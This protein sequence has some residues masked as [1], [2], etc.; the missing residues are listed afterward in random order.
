MISA[1][2]RRSFGSG[3]H[4]F[5]SC[6]AAALFC[7]AGHFTSGTEFGAVVGPEYARQIIAEETLGRT[8]RGIRWVR[9]SSAALAENG[10][11]QVAV[12][13]LP[14]RRGPGQVAESLP[15]DLFDCYWFCR[16]NLPKFS[17]IEQ[18]WEIYNEPDFYFVLDNADHMAAVLKAC[19]WG[20]KAG[21]PAAK[22]LMPPLAFVPG[23]YA[24]EL[25]RNDLFSY[26]E[27]YNFHFYGW[28]Q[29]FPRVLKAHEGYR[30]AYAA[31]LPIWMT[32]AGYYSLTAAGR[33]NPR[34]LAEQQAFHEQMAVLGHSEGIDFYFPFSV[35]PFQEGQFDLAMTTPDLVPRPALQSY[36]EL[37]KKLRGT[38]PLFQLWHTGERAQ[39]GVVLELPD[40]SW[41]SIF[42]SPRR[43]EDLEFPSNSHEAPPSGLPATHSTTFPLHLRFFREHAF[44]ESGLTEGVR[45]ETPG[46]VWFEVS[47]EKNLFL[48]SPAGRFEIEGCEWRPFE[49]ARQPGKLSARAAKGAETLQIRRSRRSEE[50][51]E[52]ALGRAPSP[53]VLQLRYDELITPDKPSQTYRFNR[54]LPVHGWLELYN[55]S[56][57]PRAGRIRLDLPPGWAV[58]ERIG[59]KKPEK[60]NNSYS[61][62]LTIEGLSKETIPIH[63]VP[64]ATLEQRDGKAAD[65]FATRRS[66]IQCQWE[67][68]DGRTTEAASWLEPEF[69]GGHPNVRFPMQ[70]WT[71]LRGRER[72]WQIGAIAEQMGGME[73]RLA[74]KPEEARRAALIY[75]FREEVQLR[76]EDLLRLDFRIVPSRP[77]AT[78]RLN[79]ITHRKDIFRYRDDFPATRSWVKLAWRIEDF[80]P[81]LWTRAESFALEPA[82]ARY[83]FFSFDG[84]EVGD[85]VEIANFG[86]VSPAPGRVKAREG[87]A[88]GRPGSRLR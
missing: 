63:F 52:S 42:W 28:A 1:I 54:N 6:M 62:E 85:R 11:H 2:K 21:A 73:F 69:S 39:I 35:T 20:V 80:S 18:V 32:E 17:G 49:G 46:E 10:F 22:V 60:P 14:N 13:T 16:T 71:A 36:L 48:R 38:R 34:R 50:K 75:A 43:E 33:T 61:A 59:L 23:K 57:E 8:N 26:T 77:A 19:Y 47:A 56:A 37:A 70:D 40:Q 84:L 41:W 67:G 25:A 82:E 55:F 29:D 30:S 7:L 12:A 51:E 24:H 9:A 45:M 66:L 88:V 31:R 15:K 64:P 65:S 87:Q 74:Q 44:L 58:W 76:R 3:T 81:S 78:V 4:R 83:L 5:P 53:V 27:G 79:L 68:R 86:L 72:E